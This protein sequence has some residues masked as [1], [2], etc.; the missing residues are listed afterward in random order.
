MSAA[1]ATGPSRYAERR[2]AARLAAVQAVYQL[3]MSGRGASA[4]VKEFKDHRLTEDFGEDGVDIDLFCAIVEGVVE[5]QTEIDRAIVNVLAQGW[6][7]ER[8]DATARAILRA[9]GFELLRRP[10]IPPNVSID[11]YIDVANAF[12]DESS[13][14][15]FINGALDAVARNAS[16][17]AAG[18]TGE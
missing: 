10:D 16:N 18:P 9:G 17:G 2:A 4:I 8:L 5:A 1:S 14:P 11:A 12:F 6:K 13:E 7:L 15:K 3:E